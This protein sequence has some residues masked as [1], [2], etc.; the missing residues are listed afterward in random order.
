M[1]AERKRVLI[2]DLIRFFA[3]EQGYRP[4]ATDEI[5]DDQLWLTFRALLNTRPAG[6]PPQEIIAKQD[7]CLQIL[8]TERGV[9]TL[10]DTIT[11]PAH[12]QIRLWRGDI[13]RLQVDT[14][15]NAAN[16]QMTG[17]WAANH[18]CIDNAIH[19]FAGVQLRAHCSAIMD[20]QGALEPSGQAK[21]TPAYNLPA[22][23]VIHTV[24]PIAQGRPSPNHA[25]E[26]ASCYT[27]C[28]D[29]AAAH[30]L[31]SI[32][33]CC[34]STGVF[35]YPAHEAATIAV[36]TVNAWLMNARADLTVVFNVF[37]AQ[38]ECIYRDLLGLPSPNVLP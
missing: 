24:G 28:L 18:A 26:L 31:R 23:Y 9:A 11:A 20:A 13:T 8:C 14:I 36:A 1:T 22:R 38:D 12:P 29:I 37:S 35:G 17:C 10:D 19:T 34:I 3:K 6:L 7:A 15:V 30:R 2:T 16:A 4:P 27:A 25:Q 33:F 32:A 21:I 5:D